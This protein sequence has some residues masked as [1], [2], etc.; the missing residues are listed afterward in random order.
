MASLAL[1]A[2]GSTDDTSTD[3]TDTAVADT[4]EVTPDVTPDVGPDVC[5]PKC[6]GKECG[7]DGCGGDCGTCTAPETCEAGVC[8]CE[9]E[10]T[11]RECGDDGCGGFCG[12]GDGTCP[13][14]EACT[15]AGV[16]EACQLP[17]TWDAVGHVATTVTPK[18]EVEYQAI[19][20][21]FDGDGNGDNAAALIADQANPV[22]QE[23]LE[24]GYYGA[25]GEFVGVADFVDT[26]SFVLNIL[27]AG[28]ATPGGTELSV[29]HWSYDEATCLPRARFLNA[30]ITNGILTA[31]PQD[32]ETSVTY[33]GMSG[34]VK[35]LDVSVTGH[36]T[37]TAAGVTL[38]DGVL[39]GVFTKANFDELAATATQYCAETDPQPDWCSKLGLLELA[40][41]LFDLDLDG[42]TV[43]DAASLCVKFTLE[44]ATVVGF[45]LD[46]F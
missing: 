44:P 41:A 42:D 12:G 33:Q 38:T 30:S 8:A 37:A 25:V 5:V 27:E 22:F 34:S 36:V 15:D 14:G 35:L 17:T 23:E 39:A 32:M 45:G 10:C 29:N 1:L 26:A 2:C 7:D 21:D 40:P 24:K 18:D 16:C 31:G 3:V 11:G 20:P 6:T 4:A 19:C 46:G 13:A 28:T 9:P 43:K